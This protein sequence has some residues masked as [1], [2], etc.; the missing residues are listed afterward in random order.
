MEELA[1]EGFG[2]YL[3][4]L[5]ADGEEA[6][7]LADRMAVTVSRFFRE[8]ECWERLSAKILS[9]ALASPSREPFRVWS[10]GCCGGEEP[11]T[12]VIL[13]RELE[14]ASGARRP[15]EVTATDID[16][17][18]LD[19]AAA[20]IYESGSLR[21]VPGPARERWFTRSGGRWRIDAL[22]RESVAFRALNLDGGPPG[23]G[24]DLVLCRYL[25]FTYYRGR[26][27]L[28]AARRI[29]S[30]LGS[31]GVLFTGRKEGLG[32]AELELFTPVDGR[33]GIYRKRGAA[34]P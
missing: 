11:C 10:A 26:R 30:S 34:P 24:F 29:S 16:G 23:E 15:L 28:D 33:C 21:E 22:I 31:G 3:S 32:P 5:E 8:R 25:A 19:R 2:D 14:E 9:P 6:A 17:P 27:R 1:I 20:G 18:S 4:L 13:W 7:A 12:L